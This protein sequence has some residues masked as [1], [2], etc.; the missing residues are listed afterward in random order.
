MVA[1]HGAVEASH[2]LLTGVRASDGFTRLWEEG[3]LDLSV[4]FSVLLPKYHDLFTGDERTEA[5][6]RLDQYEFDVD[7]QLASWPEPGTGARRPTVGSIADAQEPVA[8]EAPVVVPV[9]GSGIW[10]T[11][12]DLIKARQIFRS[13]ESRDVFYRAATYLVEQALQGGAPITLSEALVVLLQTWNRAYYQYHPPGPDHLDQIGLLLDRYASWRHRIRDRTVGT[14][15]SADAAE[16]EAI[17]RA[18]EK[19][20]GPVGAAKALHLLAPRFLPLWDRAIAVAYGLQ[21]GYTGTNSKRY[22]RMAEIAKAQS[23]RVGGEG[24]FGAD[25]LKALDEYNYCRFTK[26]WM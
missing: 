16:L 10:P 13:R 9:D 25:I 17:F 15:C 20:L 14:F 12:A 26:G 5:R 7:G 3:R 4:E 23:A 6:R 19:V 8:P 21:L 18:F 2:R 11:A 24:S 22:V 1:D